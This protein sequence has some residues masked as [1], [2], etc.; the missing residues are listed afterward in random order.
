MLSNLSIRNF[1]II[2]DLSLKIEP[3]FVVLTGET[4]A[5]KSIILDAVTLVL[6]GRSDSTMVRAG[7]SQAQLEA[8]FALT[9]ALQEEINPLLVEEGLESDYPDI[10]SLG[11]EIRDNGRSIARVNGRTVSLA[12]LRRIAEPLVDIH[13]QG[14]HL[15]LLRPQAHLPLLDS[16]AGLDGRRREFGAVVDQLRAVQNELRDLRRDQRLIAQRVDMLGYQI[17]EIDAASLRVDEEEELRE[18]R[19][20]LANA[21][22]LQ[23][24]T[25]EITA[26]LMGAGDDASAAVDLIGQAE[27][28]LG[29]L[30]EVDDVQLELLYELQGLSFQLSEISSRVQHYQDRLE[31]NPQRLDEVEE[32]IELIIDL[33]RKY[34]STIADILATRERAAAELD[35]ISNSE[36]RIAALEREQERL[37]HQVGELGEALSAARQESAQALSTAV[38]KHLAELYMEGARFAV[39]FERE[40]SED[41]AYGIDGRYAF[42]RSGLDRAEFIISANPG[43]P[44]KPMARVASGGETARLMLALKSALA[45]VDATPTLIFDEIDQG[46]GGRVGDIVGRKLWGLAVEG[47]HQVIIV[48]HLPQLAG[49]GDAHLHVSKQVADGRTTTHIEPLD[50]TGRINELAAMLGTDRKTAVSGAVSILDQVQKVKGAPES[51]VLRQQSLNL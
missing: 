20:R 13:G 38:E 4:G 35:Q 28:A 30:A 2:D 29:K 21:E 8:E 39:S 44:L 18:E 12:L 5:G 22:L 23:R 41:G 32:R 36:E 42:D 51:Q 9:P 19:T 46:I 50:R 11:R 10:L 49:Y 15:S 37:L 31:H 24:L 25:S 16:Y 34:G 6:G 14:E 17:E 47:E 7:S 3:G 43:E 33:K 48:T 1:A 27:R 40:P 45:A 26:S